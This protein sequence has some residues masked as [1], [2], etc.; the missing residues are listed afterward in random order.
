MAS[1]GTEAELL[2]LFWLHIP[3]KLALR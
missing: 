2:G 1:E 3:T